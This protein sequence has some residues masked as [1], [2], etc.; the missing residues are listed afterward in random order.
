MRLSIQ[1]VAK[2]CH[3]ANRAYCESIGDSTQLPWAAAPD[4]Q[5][6]SA[7]NGVEYH[8]KMG[9]SGPADSHENWLREKLNAGWKYGTVKDVEKKEHPCCVPYGELPLEQRAKDSIFVAIV[10]A[11]EPLLTQV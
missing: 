6:E 10:R 4:W 7:I 3:E 2:I 9:V 1:D 5:K 11:L 8:V